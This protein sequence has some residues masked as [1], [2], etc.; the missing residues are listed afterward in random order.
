MVH[1]SSA[2]PESIIYGHRQR[3]EEAYL[4]KKVTRLNCQVVL[5]KYRYSVI[6]RI[7]VAEILCTGMVL[8]SPTEYMSL[9]CR[10]RASPPAKHPCSI[11]LG[12]K[13]SKSDFHQ[14][15]SASTIPNSS[16]ILSS[17]TPA[18]MTSISHC[19]FLAGC[20]VILVGM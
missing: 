13:S 15:P 19:M 7:T 8:S 17:G 20:A 11:I 14:L 1:V 2:R 5:P 3:D 12:N 9:D 6:H 18:L 4:L 10:M 16:N